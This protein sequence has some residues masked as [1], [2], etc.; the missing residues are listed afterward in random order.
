MF[1]VRLKHIVSA[2][3]LLALAGCS[4]QSTTSFA[5]AQPASHSVAPVPEQFVNLDADTITIKH[6]GVRITGEAPTMNKKYGRILGYF[7]G[8]TS[9]T[10]EIVKATA[11]T[12]IVFNNVDTSAPHTA[13][14]L[15]DANS[16]GANWPPAFNGSSKQSAAGT[17]IETTNFSTGP[18]TP[19]TKSL[20]YNTGSPG[21]YMFGC[22]YHYNL[23]GMRTII[24]VM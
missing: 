17:N 1:P 22:F 23:D 7:N 12:T 21:F 3:T 11:A 6:V 18:L 24:I 13:S 5:P 9:L 20:K 16:Q 15:G 8:K 14:F 4:G 19:G 2:A 10:S